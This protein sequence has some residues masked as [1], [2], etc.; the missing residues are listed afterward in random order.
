[1]LV[2]WGKNDIFFGPQRALAFQKDLKDVEV[3]VKYWTFSIRRGF[4]Y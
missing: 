2:V 1:M 4:R 3:L